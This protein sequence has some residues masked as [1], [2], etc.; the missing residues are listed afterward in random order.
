MNQIKMIT[1]TTEAIIPTI[2]PVLMA[3]GNGL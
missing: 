1:A 3:Q 2:I